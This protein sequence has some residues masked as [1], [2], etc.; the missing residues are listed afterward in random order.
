[1]KKTTTVYLSGPMSGLPNN[2]F[3]TFH[4]TARAL[5]LLGYSVVNPAELKTEVTG[6]TEEQ[7]WREFMKTDIKMLVH[8]DAIVML[9]G[10]NESR[11]A[12]LERTIA[13]SLS[14]TVMSLIDAVIDHPQH[15]EQAALE[16][17]EMAVAVQNAQAVTAET[18]GAT[19]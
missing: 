14:M 16:L 2:N 8:C 10:W 12:T 17:Q 4:S 7:A 1:M 5:R 15:I 3:P 13:K 19:A 6:L 18:E 11:G 9:P